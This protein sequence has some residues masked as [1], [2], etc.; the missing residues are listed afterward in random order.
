M[1]LDMNNHIVICNWNERGKRVVTELHHPEGRP[2]VDIVIV[3]DATLDEKD[4]GRL[5]GSQ[6]IHCI[7]RDPMQYGTMKM[8]K[9][10]VADAVIVLADY[11]R[12]NPDA[13][14][15]MIILAVLG[16][17]K[18]T[19]PHIITEVANSDNSQHL[20]DAGAD[21]TICTTDIGVGILAHCVVNRQLSI[22][23]KDLLTYTFEGNEIYVVPEE[24]YDGSFIGKTFTECAQ[25]LNA[26]RNP[27]NPAIL[28]GIRRHDQV[29]LNPRRK[30][31]ERAGDECRIEK[32]DAL[33][34]MAFFA[35]NLKSGFQTP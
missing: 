25:I 16:E 23:Y 9:V 28:L 21:E 5:P 26:N 8:A 11:Q 10:S 18:E 30:A 15:A 27:T 20:K 29:L 35:P 7:R 22:V 1:Q 12:P 24:S 14:S 34:V 3:D 13:K 32:G 17:C 4:I 2:D 31:W 33:I 19:R 6:K